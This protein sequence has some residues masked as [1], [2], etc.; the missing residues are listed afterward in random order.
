MGIELLAPAGDFDCVRA[1]VSAGADAIYVGASKFSARQNATNFDKEELD[2][3]ISYCHIRGVKVYLAI[4]TLIGDVEL[5]DALDKA[6]EAYESGVDAFIVQD[7]GFAKLIRDF[8]DIPVHASTQMTVFDS[9]GIEFLKKM[10]IKRVVLARECSKKEIEKLSKD[11]EVE[12]EIFCHGAICVSYSGQCLMSSLIGGRSANRGLCAQPCRLPYSIDNKKAYYLS[13]KDL[14]LVDY[15]AEIKNAKVASLKI[16]GRMKGPSYVASTVSVFR[17]AIDEGRIEEKDKEMLIKAFSRGGEFTKGCYGEIKGKEMMN[18]HSS[19]DNVLKSAD[20]NFVKG[21]KHHWADGKEN[22]K[23]Q[24]KACF[25]VKDGKTVFEITD[26]EKN[27]VVITRENIYEE[28]GKALDENFAA[29][30]LNKMG[31]TPYEIKDLSINICEKV[32]YSASF[33]NALRREAVEKLSS[34]RDKKRTYHKD[35]CVEKYLPKEKKEFYISASVSNEKQAKALTDL[36]IKVYIPYDI[37][38]VKGCHGIIIPPVFEERELNE[39]CDTVLAG[40]IGA[41][42]FALKKGK[43]VVPDI[44][45]NIYNSVSANMFHSVTLSPELSLQSCKIIADSVSSE[46]LAYGYL[47]LMTMKNCIIKSSGKCEGKNCNGCRKTM[48]IK[49]RKGISFKIVS[50]GKINTLYN[51]VP[52][53]MADKLEDI[54]KANIDGVRLNFTDETPEECVSICKMYQEKVP[55]IMPE[56]Y[57]RGHF[58]KGY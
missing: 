44:G 52:I 21:L 20:E 35:I 48:T 11:S 8:F 58:Y 30:Q 2:K 23:I 31:S 3:A 10:G 18:I 40:S 34:L 5:K 6:K 49:D 50:N 4:N 55:V 57:T 29:S 22:K 47:P 38:Y 19:N 13:P 33:L 51:S 1:A 56:K 15:L 14:S 42:E 25:E 36:G 54:K 43:K 32:Y 16:E 41:Y 46:V 45:M 9:N 12:T 7:I 27:T 37:P 26:D 24:L 39:D 28:K 17:K 53:F